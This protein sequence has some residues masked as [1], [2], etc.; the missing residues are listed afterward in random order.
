MNDE[1]KLKRRGIVLAETKWAAAHLLAA[2]TARPNLFDIHDIE[3]H[4]IVLKSAEMA[5]AENEAEYT[6]RFRPAG[7]HWTDDLLA[8]TASLAS[9]APLAAE[10]KHHDGN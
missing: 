8:S 9:T 10:G 3:V 2:I 4:K 5:C 1:T 7:W 6:R